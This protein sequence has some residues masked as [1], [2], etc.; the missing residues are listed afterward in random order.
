MI[1]ELREQE[2][3]GLEVKQHCFSHFLQFDHCW[4][5]RQMSTQRF[6]A[7]FH[8]WVNLEQ[9]LSRIHIHVRKEDTSSSHAAESN[10]N[11]K[12]QMATLP[13]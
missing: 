7:I 10:K 4:A 11:S 9:V 8:T 5:P 3:V 1:M 12:I 6:N 2:L 13:V